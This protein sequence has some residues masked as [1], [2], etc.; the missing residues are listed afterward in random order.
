MTGLALF[1]LALGAVWLA[2][3]VSLIWDYATRRKLTVEQEQAIKLLVLAG[4]DIERNGAHLYKRGTLINVVQFTP[5][6]GVGTT[7]DEKFTDLDKA[8]ER[9]AGIAA[10]K[11]PGTAPVAAAA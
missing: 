2:A 3:L 9:F 5:G 11:E 1:Q 6:A 7:V 8:I 4:Y 10:P